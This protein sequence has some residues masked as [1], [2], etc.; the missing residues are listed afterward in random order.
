M[1]VYCCR[2]ANQTNP[3]DAACTKMRPVCVYTKRR[4]KA[5]LQRES[6]RLKFNSARH[7]KTRRHQRERERRPGPAEKER[8]RCHQS[9]LEEVPRRCRAPA[10]WP[11]SLPTEENCW[12]R[13]SN[14][15]GRIERKRL[16]S[17]HLG[18]FFFNSIYSIKE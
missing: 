6:V 1:C 18:S 13:H 10:A 8:R 5:L 3:E 16:L 15:S 9:I 11:R 4:N 14:R 12:R 17:R 2:L 7:Y